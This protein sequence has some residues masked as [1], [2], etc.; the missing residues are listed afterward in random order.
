MRRIAAGLLKNEHDADDAAQDAWV[1]ALGSRESNTTL[2]AWLANV[3]KN[4]AFRI[5]RDRSRRARREEA[6]ARPEATATV[7]E[8]VERERARQQILAAVLAL[9]EPYKTAVLLRYFE[10]LPPREIAKRT[11]EPI[12]TVKTRLKRG[13]GDLRSS[14]TTTLGAGWAGWCLQ[15]VRA[16]PSAGAIYAPAAGNSIIYITLLIMSK[17]TILAAVAIAAAMLGG[18][19][20]MQYK[21]SPEPPPRTLETPPVASAP[22]RPRETHSQPSAAIATNPAPKPA[23]RVAVAAPDA[24]IKNKLE[25]RGRVVDEAGAPL[26][27]WNVYQGAMPLRTGRAGP[28]IITDDNGA[29]HFTAAEAA[30]RWIKVYDPKSKTIDVPEGVAEDVIPGGPEVLITVSNAARASCYIVGRLVVPGSPPIDAKSIFIHEGSQTGSHFAHSPRVDAEKFTFRDGPCPPHLYEVEINVAG[31]GNWRS[32]KKR[33]KPNETWDLGDITFANPGKLNITA[34]R[35][36]GEIESVPLT[37]YAV[38]ADRDPATRRPDNTLKFD[39]DRYESPP[40]APGKYILIWEADSIARESTAVEVRSDETG[41]Y[42][43]TTHPGFRCYVSL[44]IK[45]PTPVVASVT[46]LFHGAYGDINY[47]SSIPPSA[48]EYSF[49]PMLRSGVYDLSITTGAELTGSTRFEL[50]GPG[51]PEKPVVVELRK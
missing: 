9:E 39:L 42:P 24:E 11:G 20:L 18:A 29:F 38:P 26:A 44:R 34:R 50:T 51:D 48:V 31:F 2:R 17:K 6:V 4:F 16:A 1:A 8:I 43:I 37:M 21:Y 27:G 30:P 14:V 19:A 45:K 7:A 12:G 22:E 33:L 10:N 5:I 28:P 23:P 35:D 41:T 49:A 15:I 32:G 47:A 25:I 13:L 36:T 3:T 40:L 46:L